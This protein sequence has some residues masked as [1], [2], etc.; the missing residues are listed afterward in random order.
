MPMTRP[1][2]PDMSPKGTKK[3]TK[4]YWVTGSRVGLEGSDSV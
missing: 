2:D 4:P 1:T 3:D